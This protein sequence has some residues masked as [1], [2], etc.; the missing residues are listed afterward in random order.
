MIWIK[1]IY[2]KVSTHLWSNKNLYTVLCKNL[3]PLIEILV[4]MQFCKNY[5]FH[6]RT[7]R[8]TKLF[9]KLIFCSTSFVFKNCCNPVM[10]AMN[11]R[12]PVNYRNLYTPDNVYCLN[13]WHSTGWFIFYNFI[14]HN[15][16]RF[17]IEFKSW[18]V[19]WSVK[20]LDFLRLQV[21]LSSLWPCDTVPYHAWK[22]NI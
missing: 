9:I 22:L 8:L 2:F 14:F 21:V 12:L 18:A 20:H 16:H 7:N 17:S 6:K 11:K 10:Q 13:K 5:I 15:N 4:L 19:T 3:R 1:Y